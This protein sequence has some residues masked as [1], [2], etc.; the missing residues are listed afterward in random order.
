MAAIVIF[1]SLVEFVPG[2]G[3]P[4]ELLV[5]IAV[6]DLPG[7]LKT[8]LEE[9]I[10]LPKVQFVLAMKPSSFGADLSGGRKVTTTCEKIERELL[11]PSQAGHPKAASC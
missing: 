5:P 2:F 10:K 4:E 8:V 9:H 7:S 1:K 3:V 6:T 11:S